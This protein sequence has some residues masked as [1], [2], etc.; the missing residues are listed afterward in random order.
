MVEKTRDVRVPTTQLYLSP[1]ISS[2]HVLP[3]SRM[4][5]YIFLTTFF[6]ILTVKA[7]SFPSCSPSLSFFRAHMPVESFHCASLSLP[8][9]LF[10]SYG[11]VYAFFTPKSGYFCLEKKK[12]EK[13]AY[14]LHAAR[15]CASGPCANEAV[16]NVRASA[17]ARRTTQ[18]KGVEGG[19]KRIGSKTAMV[20]KGK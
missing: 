14:S 15:G 11:N 4:S 12:S 18:R 7:R 5:V 3:I 16:P 2:L 1:S 17:V 19:G 10:P 6:L 13:S 20:A 9:L 8:F